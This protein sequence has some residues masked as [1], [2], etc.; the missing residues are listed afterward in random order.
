MSAGDQNHSRAAQFKCL[1]DPTVPLSV[2]IVPIT[3]ARPFIG[4]S[5]ECEPSFPVLGKVG[6]K[7]FLGCFAVAV[8][9]EIHYRTLRSAFEGFESEPETRG[10]SSGYTYQAHHEACPSGCRPMHPPCS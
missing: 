9:S 5:L 6:I 7:M 2:W 3:A 10:N 4:F 8:K 1:S